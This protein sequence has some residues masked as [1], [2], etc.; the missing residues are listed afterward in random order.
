MLATVLV[1]FGTAV[2]EADVLLDSVGR[3]RHT[4]AALP[5]L[6]ASWMLPSS[7]PEVAELG[8]YDLPSLTD[9]TFHGSYA[10]ERG[11]VTVR[12]CLSTEGMW[13][14]LCVHPAQCSA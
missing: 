1:A 3:W 10:C 14:S 12:L 5:V 13:V 2:L 4:K 7:G 8:L 9:P 6:Q 11:Y